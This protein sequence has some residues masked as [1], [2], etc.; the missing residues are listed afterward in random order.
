MCCQRQLSVIQQSSLCVGQSRIC[1]VSLFTVVC[2]RKIGNKKEREKEKTRKQTYQRHIRAKVD[3]VQTVCSFLPTLYHERDTQFVRWSGWEWSMQSRLS[4]GP[5]ARIMSG[6][7]CVCF[8]PGG[9]GELS[10]WGG[11]FHQRPRSSLPA[12]LPLRRSSGC[13][14]RWIRWRELRRAIPYLPFPSDPAPAFW[15]RWRH[16]HLTS[17]RQFWL[18]TTYFFLH[19]FLICNCY[20]LFGYL[21]TPGSFSMAYVLLHLYF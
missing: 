15:D 17:C 18:I 20:V 6:I 12:T 3:H 13:A 5:T 21:S 14:R 7:H 2:Q 11:S 16:P 19:S 4:R 10:L 9:G 1:S 8:T